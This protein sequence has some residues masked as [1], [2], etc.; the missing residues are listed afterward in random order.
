MTLHS[1]VI[2]GHGPRPLLRYRSLVVQQ[3][4]TVGCRN[5]S[6]SY[7]SAG[8]ARVR[9][10]RHFL[11]ERNRVGEPDRVAEVLHHQSVVWRA[12]ESRI[13]PERAARRGVKVVAGGAADVHI[14]ETHEKNTS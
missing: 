13:P 2:R 7:L 3:H 12:A 4:G 6:K 9:W 11:H 10:E 1:L 14:R 8:H 5:G